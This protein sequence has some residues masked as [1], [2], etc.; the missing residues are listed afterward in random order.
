MI[1]RTIGRYRILER[2]GRGGMGEVFAAVDTSLD[3][4]VAVKVLPPEVAGDA[5]RLERFRREARTVAALNHPNIVTVHAV[6]EAD[7]VPLLV[8]ELVEGRRLDELIPAGG[9]SLAGLLDVAIPV[10]DAVAAAHQR[11][12]VHRDLKPA[13]V[14]VTADG[15]V[16]VLDFGLAKLLPA[17]AADTE[18][19]SAGMTGAG[20]VLGTVPYM[21]PEQLA[22]APVDHRSDVF[23]LGVVLFEMATGVR[24]FRGDSSALLASAILRDEPPA[25]SELKPELPR[26]VR[27]CL[28]KEPAERFQT[29]L[30]VRN[31]L[32]QLR[33]EVESGESEVT[34][35]TAVAARREALPAA[36]RRWWL[37]AA[38]VAGAL[39]LLA[40]I[41]SRW[42]A[43]AKEAGAAAAAA[44]GRDA[45]APAPRPKIVV[46]PFENLGRP[47]DEYFADGVSE[48]ITSRLASLD[49]LGVISR[50]SAMRY[51][52]ERPP[53]AQIGRDL[54][55][56]YILEG[57]V[58]WEHAAAGPSR[59]RVTPQLI[60]VADD[61]HLWST[62]FDEE[63]D[64]IFAVQTAI[65]EEVARQLDV[66]LLS[67]EQA[68]LAARP[69]ANMEAYQAYLRGNELWMAPGFDDERFRVAAE[70]FARATQMDPR[71]LLAWS[72]LTEVNG[73]LYRM[74]GDAEDLAATRAALER[75]QALD[76]AHPR[77]LFAA[78]IYEYAQQHYQQA[79]E[80]L[81]PAAAQ[82]PNDYDMQYMLGLVQRRLGDLDAAE[83]HLRAVHEIDPQSA[84]ALHMLAMTL[85]ARR[86]FAAAEE[87]MARAI[88]IA[89][90]E[91]ALYEARAVIRLATGD[92]TGAREVLLAAPG[93]AEGT[94][95]WLHV[96]VV[97]RDF[98]AVRRQ[99]EAR[100]REIAP[101]EGGWLRL[102][103][104]ELARHEGRSADAQKHF[105]EVLA[106][107]Q[108]RLAAG[109][110]HGGNLMLAARALAGLGR[111]DEALEHG[112]R[113]V[114]A[115]AVD[116]F[117]GPARKV[118]FAIVLLYVGR[119]DEAIEL[120]RELLVEEYAEPLTVAALRDEPIWD[121]LRGNPRFAALLR[122][123]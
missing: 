113:A 88:A 89:P 86:R 116:R 21:S 98:A 48:E 67:G 94:D 60:R 42:N 69:T 61:T 51:K 30:D 4:R 28:E 101:G 108:E 23:S 38:A 74:S 81:Q 49:G 40:L 36:R 14:M 11:G 5:E 117:S 13:N 25:V 55:V 122:P 84:A 68:A 105:T 43:P 91:P 44:I 77:T 106:L 62:R 53:V 121:P 8:L 33:R 27:H 34:A 16:K 78:A 115:D 102:T 70:V 7:G 24:P 75:A 32:K 64:A 35:T 63:L 83:R 111:A 71:F 119:H 110:M 59:V 118:D 120:L 76:P 56:D 12:I 54:G 15:R 50:T 10:A 93:G 87:T 19:V 85:A 66:R 39:A 92:V 26:I 96:L 31:E 17:A 104:A 103:L 57:T 22:G 100:L 1:G 58:R 9:L 20:A 45:K 95:A 65:A 79:L 114:A 109:R 37:G 47:E 18:T 41:A 73:Q 123:S 82:L 72:R 6:E 46:L 97:Q 3:R 99:C 2:L 52:G 80:A 90:D 29:A 112:R 107:A